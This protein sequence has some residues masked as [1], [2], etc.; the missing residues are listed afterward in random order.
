MASAAFG[1]LWD[2]RMSVARQSFA[3]QTMRGEN[4][5]IARRQGWRQVGCDAEIEHLAGHPLPPSRRASTPA[6][7]RAVHVYM[8]ERAPVT[9][10]GAHP[11]DHAVPGSRYEVSMRGAQGGNEGLGAP[12]LRVC[13]ANREREQRVAEARVADQARAFRGPSGG[14]DPG[15]L[16]RPS[17]GVSIPRIDPS[18]RFDITEAY[19]CQQVAHEGLTPGDPDMTRLADIGPLLPAR[20]CA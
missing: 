17:A 10:P 7:Q 14:L 19:A 16:Q 12:P 18:S 5:H 8:H 2:D 3:Q 1:L 11:A 15:R 20:Q 9:H 6:R 4:D 13:H